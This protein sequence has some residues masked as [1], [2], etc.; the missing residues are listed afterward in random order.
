MKKITRK[1]LIFGILLTA[2]FLFVFTIVRQEADVVIK[3]SDLRAVGAAS[4]V[5]GS[6]TKP[7]NIITKE[8][9]DEEDEE[10]VVISI[11]NFGRK[12]PFE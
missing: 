12:N 3:K 6:A 8:F 10:K 11:V 5:S 4:Q 1:S 2:V 7:V 9:P